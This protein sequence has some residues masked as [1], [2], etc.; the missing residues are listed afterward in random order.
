MMSNP[1]PIG[2]TAAEN[3]GSISVLRHRLA[4]WLCI[5]SAFIIFLLPLK[6]GGIVGVPE[7]IFFPDSL[8]TW[9]IFTWPVLMFPAISA[10]LLLLAA[11]LASGPRLNFRLAISLIWVFLALASLIGYVNASTKDFPILEI[12]HLLGIASFCLAVYFL[13]ESRP[14]MKDL[15]INAIVLSAVFSAFMG[16][17]Q[18][19]WGFRETLDYVYQ[20]EL[21]TGLKTTANLQNRLGQTRVYSPFTICNSLAAHLVLTIPLCILMIWKSATVLKSVI[22]MSVTI[23]FL[24]LAGYCGQLGF[25]LL[26]TAWAAAVLVTLF[27]FP[28]KHTRRISF[29]L[30]LLCA[31]LMFTILYFTGSR[32]AVLAFGLAIAVSAAIFPFNLKIRIA[33]AISV[34]AATSAGLYFINAGRHLDSMRVRLDYFSVALKIFKENILLGTGWG[35]FFHK[36]TMLKSFPGTE[37]PHT[38][39]NFI[40]DF[41]SQAGIVG[42]SASLAAILFPLI[43]ILLKTKKKTAL[44]DFALNFALILGWTAWTLHSLS[45]INIQ[46][47]GTVATALLMIM[48][49]KP[50]DTDSTIDLSPA[51][52]RMFSIVLKTAACLLAAST[53]CISAKRLS[54]EFYMWELIQLCEPSISTQGSHEPATQSQIETALKNAVG[55]IPYSPFPWA[56]A[57][58][59]TQ[60]SRNWTMTEIF[61]ANALALSPERSSFYHHLATAQIMQGKKQ[62]ALENM[63]KAC[64]LF[65][66]SAEYKDLFGKLSEDLKKGKWEVKR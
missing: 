26:A 11:V 28:E 22:A 39:H 17:Q 56:T 59:Y 33:C 25:V 30:C 4:G 61:Y 48:L 55:E 18:L 44:P 10:L 24:S 23:V 45:D 8:I 63:R 58:N 47:P 32:G 37:A 36:Y 52:R 31:A 3:N 62:E 66:N 2:K 21:K 51:R 54:G 57:G 6:F 60:A 46:V 13:V 27:K 19:L 42:L 50:D 40:L 16:L 53:L 41:A 9:F 14:D 20:Q 64:I 34:I 15:L 49:L 35:D 5:L 7:V 12:A 1:D 29:A 43:L 65:P 38:S